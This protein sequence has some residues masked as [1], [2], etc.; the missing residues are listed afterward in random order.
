MGK[1]ERRF[2][3][4]KFERSVKIQKEGMEIQSYLAGVNSGAY[5]LPYVIS[6][7]TW[8]RKWF[9]RKF[10]YSEIQL[11]LMEVR[12]LKEECEKVLDYFD[13]SKTTTGNV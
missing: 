2:E 8:A 10:F 9:W 1:T 4:L 5:G 7:R 13:R 6:V 3:T 11:N 12:Q